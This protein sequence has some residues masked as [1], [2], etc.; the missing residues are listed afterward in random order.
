MQSPSSEASLRNV[1]DKIRDVSLS[2][3]TNRLVVGVDFGTTYSGVAWGYTGSP[4]EIHVI[5]S[6]PGGVNLTSPKVP[7][8]IAYEKDGIK[9]GFQIKPFQNCIE[10][11]K[12]CLDPNLRPPD[13]VSLPNIY[14]QLQQHEKTVQDVVRDYLQMLYD[15]TITMLTRSLGQTFV[16][17]TKI[18]FILTCPAV[19]SDRSKNATLQ[20]AEGTGMAKS[21]K[22]RLISE[23]EAA[24]LYTLKTIRPKN[25]SANDDSCF[26]VCDAGGGTVDLISY[27]ILQT[28]PLQVKESVTGT[29]ELCGSAFLNRRF[30]SFVKERLGSTAYF[31][32]KE[33]TKIAALKS[34][35]EYVK[36]VFVDGEDQDVFP[37][38]FPGLP[39]DEARGIDCGFMTVT[40]EEVQ[41]IFEPVIEEVV[42][43]VDGQITAVQ[44]KG[45]R[46]KSILLVGGFGSSEYLFMRLQNK[47]TDVLST[48]DNPDV[49][50]QPV[51][52]W[53][54][55]VRG[56]VIRGMETI[57]QTRK[58]RYH[59]GVKYWE[60]YDENIH[61]EEHKY[62]D[63]TREKWL[64]ENQIKWYI[65][66][67]TEMSE[68][69]SIAF[70]FYI[71]FED[72][73]SRVLV[74]ELVCCQETFPPKCIDSTVK[75]VCKLRSDLTNVPK[76]MYTK[77]RNSKDVEYEGLHFTMEMTVL[78]A[79][80][81]F[82]LS[83]DGVRYGE[84]TADFA[85]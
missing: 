9:W 38:Q 56:A 74:D 5:Q 30:E 66:K 62:W 20:A 18:E 15:H 70:P 67:G 33:K 59:Y 72:H 44:S 76:S 31:A 42:R 22:I 77:G 52:S 1:T 40:R 80:L 85:T 37:I 57:V 17:N 47:Y 78:S 11:F 23:P 26:V 65:A 32:M 19:W 68:D 6:W 21:C 4:S 49:V 58:S 50:L 79:S 16:E 48:P 75:T 83:V 24:A 63:T 41:G 82:E 71:T 51:D 61:S 84:V 7:S 53:T 64:A 29:G 8:K 81:L 43:L 60:Y 55:V 25:L 27:E 35:E 2:G 46:V 69:E 12:L 45:K 73:H 3:E 10:C 34:W 39:D 54:A 36:R 13:F 28:E 14:A